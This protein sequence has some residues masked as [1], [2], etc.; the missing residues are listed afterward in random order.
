[1]SDTAVVES[2]ERDLARELTGLREQRAELAVDAAGDDESALGRLEEIETRIDGLEREVERGR[3]AAEVLERRQRESALAASEAERARLEAEAGALELERDEV[4][5]RA[6]SASRVAAGLAHEAVEIDRRIEANRRSL[7][8][9]H[10]PIEGSMLVDRVSVEFRDL[11]I[12]GGFEPLSA[13]WRRVLVQR[14][15]APAETKATVALCTICAHPQRTEVD[16]ALEAGTDTLRVL[17]ERFNVS[18]SALSR[19]RS[20]AGAASEP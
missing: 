5:G 2:V 13:S 8:T 1:M 15:P 10:R 3:I 7:G 18:R 11:G 14:W 6:V 20:H 9:S 19:H 12:Q 4:I 17:E 16:A